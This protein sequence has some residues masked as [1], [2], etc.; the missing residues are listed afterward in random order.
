MSRQ[1]RR[2][3]ERSRK[4]R[5]MSDAQFNRYLA[6]LGSLLRLS[7]QQKL[8][9]AEELRDHLEQR[10]RELVED[11]VG[12]DE[13]VSLALEEFGDAARLAAELNRTA[14]LRRRRWIVR[15]TIGTL[16]ASAAAA[17]TLMSLWPEGHIVPAPQP[18]TAQQ[19]DSTEHSSD[20]PG[21]LAE[22]SDTPE[23]PSFPEPSSQAPPSGVQAA[24][25]ELDAN[26]VTENKLAKLI[27]AEYFETPLR[28]CLDAISERLQVQFYIKTRA[29]EDEAISPDTPVTISLHDVPAE[30]VLDLVLESLD[31]AYSLRHGVIIISTPS[32]QEKNLEPV[33]YDVSDLVGKP[34]DFART[35]SL[36]VDVPPT[37]SF[38]DRT[39]GTTSPQTFELVNL[40]TKVVQADTWEK[41]GGPG[42]L[43]VYRNALVV[44]HTPDVHAKIRKFLD[45]L[46]RIH[47][48]PSSTAFQGQSPWFKR[49][50]R[51]DT[52]EG[53]VRGD[54][55]SDPFSGDAHVQEEPQSLPSSDA[56]VR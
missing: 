39:T 56:S 17:V 49:E 33:V 14:A 6:L 42:T 4:E 18:A 28:E 29:L 52:A 27:T 34:D 25:R 41:V 53:N 35:P 44:T 37:R 40:I 55:R 1:N 12:D 9:I 3:T 47:R 7:R 24:I 10:T 31:L 43:G 21:E 5:A 36:E 11:G 23:R 48:A 8:A 26:T 15:T 19:S 46:R 50:Q 38:E 54:T 2:E 22:P 16:A 51:P 13:A 45:D 32:E 20:V 30:M